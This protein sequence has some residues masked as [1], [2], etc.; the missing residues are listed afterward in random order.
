[1]AAPAT[2][3]ATTLEGQLLQLIEFV[4]NEQVNAIANA[5]PGV[6]V[7]RLIA[8]NTTDDISGTKTV[9]LSLPVSVNTNAA[10][11]ATTAVEVY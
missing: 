4:T 5:A 6:T 8:A 9:S 7:R 2:L 1:M 11:T 3:T 10:G